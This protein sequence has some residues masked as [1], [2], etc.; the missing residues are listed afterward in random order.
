[1]F[2][3]TFARTIRN[4]VRALHMKYGVSRQKGQ[5]VH[6]NFATNIAMKVSLPYFLRPQTSDLKSQRFESL[7]FRLR[8]R[9]SFPLISLALCDFKSL[10]FEIAAIPI[11]DLVRHSGTSWIYT[12]ARKS[13]IHKFLLLELNS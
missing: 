9:P 10:R 2:T 12:P 7:Q 11:C 5:K 8:F 3:R 6:S 13:Y 1:M 4:N